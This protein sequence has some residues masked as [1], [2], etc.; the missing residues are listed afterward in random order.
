MLHH[1]YSTISM[2]LCSYMDSIGTIIYECGQPEVVNVWPRSI[3][4]KMSMRHEYSGV[5]IIINVYFI[6]Y[7]AYIYL[8]FMIGFSLLNSSNQHT[9]TGLVR[10]DMCISVFI[11]WF[12]ICYYS[13]KFQRW[14]QLFIATD[15]L[16]PGPR[17]RFGRV[18]HQ[19]KSH[20]GIVV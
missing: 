9:S 13:Y 19:W 7:N 20:L 6:L 10:Y 2:V 1:W 12:W 3:A 18:R 4:F 15:W 5:C 8:K 14:I 11:E 17:I 16:H